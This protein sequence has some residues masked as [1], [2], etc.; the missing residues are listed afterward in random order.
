MSQDGSA[1]SVRDAPDKGRYEIRLD[2]EVVGFTEYF[3]HDG[4]RV[5]LHTEVDPAYGGRGLAAQLVRSALDDVRERGERIVNFCPYITTYLTKH[6][7]WEDVIDRP[8]PEILE[9]VRAR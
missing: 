8:T 2:E 7:D 5:F 1:I 4:H 6:D 9:R 3:D